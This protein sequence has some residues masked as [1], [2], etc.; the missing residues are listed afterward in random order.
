MDEQQVG[1]VLV[2][3]YGT[4]SGILTD[5]DLVIRA[6]AQGAAPDTPVSELMSVPAAT[7]DASDDLDIAYRTFRRTGVRRLPVLDA[8]RLVGVLTID[9][10]FCDVLQHF[11]DLLG[12]VSVS[13]LREGGAGPGTAGRPHF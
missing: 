10:L 4:L 7:V 2:A 1:C 5:R 3:E 8:H 11:A 13:A 6:L 9:D 12:P